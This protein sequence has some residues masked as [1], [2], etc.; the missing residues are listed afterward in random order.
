MKQGS[1]FV[2]GKLDADL[3][4]IEKLLGDKSFLQ[5]NKNVFLKVK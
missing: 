2:I 3:L 5:I 4:K 1:L